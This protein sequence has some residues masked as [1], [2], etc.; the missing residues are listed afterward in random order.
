MY[1]LDNDRRHID[2][3]AAGR[4][5]C[6]DLVDN[7]II[8]VVPAAAPARGTLTALL[9]MGASEWVQGWFPKQFNYGMYL[10]GKPLDEVRKFQTHV[11]RLA[12]E[13]D[14]WTARCR[15][16]HTGRTESAS[17]R[18]AAADEYAAKLL[19]TKRGNLPITKRIYIWGCLPGGGGT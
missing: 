1:N 5:V 2:P 14:M 17:S 4:A 18:K 3:G 19:R 16:I 11:V 15:M 12:T 9:E 6:A 8:T 7:L 13:A 10:L